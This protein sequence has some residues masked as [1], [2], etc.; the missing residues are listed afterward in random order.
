MT[1]EVFNYLGA[2]VLEMPYA[3]TINT[4]GLQKGYYML[5]LNSYFTSESITIPFAVFK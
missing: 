4:A 3:P 1:I 5:R 2:K